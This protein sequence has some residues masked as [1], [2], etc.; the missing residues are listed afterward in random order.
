MLELQDVHK[1]YAGRKILAGLSLALAAGEI[2]CLTGPSGSGKST[3]L[4]IMAGLIRPEQGRVRR[5]TEISLLFQ[6]DALIHWLNA[7]NNL[8]YILPPKTRFIPRWLER[9][10]LAGETYPPA[11]S[12][13][14]RR[15]LGLARAFAAGRKVILLDEPFAFLDQAWQETVAEEIAAQAAAGAS[16]ALTAHSP[17]T[18]NFPCLAGLPRRILPLPVPG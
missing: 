7:A 4:E 17:D 10:G 3:A 15:R 13:G 11:M 5:D 2:L 14:M 8:A 16:L 6:D 1:S 9:F 12:G 18:L